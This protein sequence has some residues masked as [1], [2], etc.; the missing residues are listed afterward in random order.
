MRKRT[1]IFYYAIILVLAFTLIPPLSPKTVE[2]DVPERVIED[3]HQ[4]LLSVMKEAKVLGYK[5][6]YDKLAP[7]I[8]RTFDLPFIARMAVGRYWR[9]FSDEEKLEFVDAFSRLSIATYAGR[10]DD[11]SGEQFNMINTDSYRRKYRMVR[12]QLSTPRGEE[13]ELNYILHQ[14]NDK[15]RV[16]NIIADGVSD[17]SLKRADY[18]TFLEKNSFEAFLHK[19]NEKISSYSE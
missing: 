17:L 11:Y 19:L 2:A 13:I 18:T 5:G 9:T 7:V 6:R 15:W 1:P 8:R 4:T 14:K 10:F 3:L 16:I 12:T